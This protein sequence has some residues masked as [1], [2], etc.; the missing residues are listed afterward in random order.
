M[1]AGEDAGAILWKVGMI[2]TVADLVRVSDDARGREPLVA[3][4]DRKGARMAR[5]ARFAMPSA[6]AS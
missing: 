3:V 2:L 1:G 6:E 5:S 4:G